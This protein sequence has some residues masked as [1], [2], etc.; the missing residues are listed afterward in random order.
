M[1]DM[2]RDRECYWEKLKASLKKMSKY[3]RLG[4]ELPH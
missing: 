4:E 2:G 3:L 1:K